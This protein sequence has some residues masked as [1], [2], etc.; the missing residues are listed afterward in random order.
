MVIMMDGDG[1]TPTGMHFSNQN[2]YP[3]PSWNQFWNLEVEPSL[4]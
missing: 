1:E 3:A 2:M 4:G